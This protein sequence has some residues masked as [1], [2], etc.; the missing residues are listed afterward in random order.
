MPLVRKLPKRGFSNAPFKIHHVVI[1][2]GKL[3]KLF[4]AGETV[5]PQTLLDR[6]VLSRIRH[7]LKV[8]GDGELSVAL[9]VKAHAFSAKAREK[10]EKAGGKVEVLKSDR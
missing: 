6:R 5:D 4:K 1:N 2:V 3:A 9:T 7:G 10:I 8:L